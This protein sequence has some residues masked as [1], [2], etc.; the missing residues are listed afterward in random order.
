MYTCIY[1]YTLEIMT[2]HDDIGVVLDDKNMCL[3]PELRIITIQWS[4]YQ[5]T[6]VHRP[7]DVNGHKLGVPIRQ[8]EKYL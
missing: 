8:Y 7:S 5:P 4:I 2:E 3:L 1:M 6:R